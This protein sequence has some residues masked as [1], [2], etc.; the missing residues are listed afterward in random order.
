M[1]CF[2]MTKEKLNSY[3]REIRKYRDGLWIP[4]RYILYNYWFQFLKIAYEE[5]RKINWKKYEDWGKPEDI[6]SIPFR[7]FW[8]QNWKRLFAEKT[9]QGRTGKFIMTSE[10]TNR[11]S[12]RV[13]LSI[14]KFRKMYP[15]IADTP[16]DQYGRSGDTNIFDK[17]EVEKI[18]T[19][20]WKNELGSLWGGET[21]QYNKEINRN[22]KRYR[23]QTEE[24]LQN[25][26][27]GRF[28]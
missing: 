16:P 27:E 23:K 28:P 25:V 20:K 2:C 10:R 21:T 7:K 9:K 15:Q 8:E 22:F 19:K 6:F 5:K 17:I 11:D 12:L 3:Q 13:C 4:H 24:V 14:Y 26:C 1:L 18:K